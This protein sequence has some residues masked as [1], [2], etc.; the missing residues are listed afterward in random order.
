MKRVPNDHG[1]SEV[2]AQ[3]GKF[4][5]EGNKD[6]LL[7][8]V[9][10]LLASALQQVDEQGA[11]I[12][13]LLRR[14]YSRSSE[15]VNP[16]QLA[17]ALAELQSDAEPD[18]PAVP[19]P[20]SEGEPRL[21]QKTKKAKRRGRKPLPPEL[22]REEIRL[23]PTQ[24][25]LAQ[26]S[27]NMSKVGEERSEVLEY[28]PAQFKVL[29][30][31]RETWSNPVGEIVTAPAADKVIDK[32]LPGPGLLTQ[33]IVSKYRD[34]LPLDRQTKIYRR[35]GVEL[36]K[37]TLGD[38]VAAVAYL[39]QPLARQIFR[40]AL[41]SHVLQVDDT[42]LPVLDRSKD[43]NIKHGRLWVLIGDHFYVAYRYAKDWRGATTAEFLSA[44]IGWMQ[45]D[46]YKGYEQ[47]YDQGLA[48]E[49]GCWMHCRRYFVEA[50]EHGDL[51]AAV[52]IELIREMY[53]IEAESKAAEDSHEERLAR[54]RRETEP[55]FAKLGQW[56]AEH[57][58]REP[59]KSYLAKA[60]TY[61][62]NQ[63]QA[64]G[65]PFEDGALELDNGDAERAL[66]GPVLGRKNWLFAG[67]DSGA[68]RTA[69]IATVL[70]SAARHGLD[71]SR[72]L[73]DV[74]IKLSSGWPNRRLDELMPH[75]WRE[76]HA[77]AR[78]AEEAVAAPSVSVSASVS[79]E[80]EQTAPP[81]TVVV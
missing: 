43:K 23:Q 19:T 74:L 73:Y 56:I 14:L 21:R 24:E 67:S 32:G 55:I 18:A 64:L 44:R 80:A 16:N 60:L 27:G 70:E 22:P 42:K 48:I 77:P 25:Q 57:A 65:R 41:S 29:V 38:W 34:H 6:A 49:V 8:E 37:N 13:A 63:W 26:T 78:A 3:L 53:R 20:P 61:A 46:G 9:G 72:Y 15:R 1:I 5:D 10:M 50:F 30:Y 71:L 51:R 52:P 33:V 75:R 68:E 76:L 69:I 11:R 31:V 58:G 40:W 4:F 47:I 81:S 59:P 7:N 54:R 79:I 62:G 36:S 66:R 12:K 17:L 2:L 35:L 45:A 28:V 39:L